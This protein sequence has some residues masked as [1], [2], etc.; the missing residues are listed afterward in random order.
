[1]ACATDSAEVLLQISWQLF[2]SF[3][4]GMHLMLQDLCFFAKLL[5]EFGLQVVAKVF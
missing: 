3:H 1:V 5:V 2:N 4:L